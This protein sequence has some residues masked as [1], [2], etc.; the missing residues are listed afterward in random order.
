MKIALYRDK[1]KKV[2]KMSKRNDVDMNLTK[3]LFGTC[4]P[5]IIRSLLLFT[6]AGAFLLLLL[7][8]LLLRLRLRLLFAFA[9]TLLFL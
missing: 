3:N 4:L 8:L 5:V 7:L 2:R 1:A 9:F 6:F